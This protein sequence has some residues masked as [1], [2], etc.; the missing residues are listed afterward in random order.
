MYYGPNYPKYRN[1][2]IIN[3]NS[4]VLLLLLFYV[5]PAHTF[6]SNRQLPLLNQQKEKQ[7]YVARPGSKPRTSD[8]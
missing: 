7:K 8:L 1:T 5:L 4:N 2:L 6:A 3:C